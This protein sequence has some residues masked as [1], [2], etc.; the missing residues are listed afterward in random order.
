MYV[1]TPI[2]TTF[3]TGQK[4]P[5]SGIYQFVRLTDPSK[6]CV[7]TANERTIPLRQGETFPPVRSCNEGA[8]WRLSRYA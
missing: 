5:V 2:G 6:T 1:T 7:P 8:I 4:A 3:R